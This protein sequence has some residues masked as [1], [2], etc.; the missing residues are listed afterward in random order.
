MLDSK[1]SNHEA[2]SFCTAVRCID[3]RVQLPVIQHL[4]RRFHVEFVDVV[5]D[6]GPA[7]VLAHDPDSE[8]ASS[9]YR[10]IDVSRDAHRS[11][12]LAI[13]AHHDYWGHQRPLEGQLDDLRRSAAHL[14]LRYPGFPVLPLWVGSGWAVEHVHDGRWP[15]WDQPCGSGS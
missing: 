12:G 7:S 3:G 13:V 1:S 9:I 8:K 10:R 15:P 11:Q 2:L 4:T 5:S 14:R 6:T